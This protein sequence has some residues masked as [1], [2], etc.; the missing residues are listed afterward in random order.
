MPHLP[1]LIFMKR[2]KFS[3]KQVYPSGAVTHEASASVTHRSPSLSAV[4]ASIGSQQYGA[5][6]HARQ[7]STATSAKVRVTASTDKS[8]HHHHH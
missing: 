6:K 5:L 2:R 8:P 4:R 1:T 7:P 3:N